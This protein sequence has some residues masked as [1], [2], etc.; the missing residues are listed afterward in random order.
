MVAS[1]S[2]PPSLGLLMLETRSLSELAAFFSL[3]P[4][5]RLSPR[6]DGHPVLVLPGLSPVVADTEPASR[7]ATPRRWCCVL[8]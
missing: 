4:A 1:P 6:G 7:Q 3:A 5:L 2:A 8:S